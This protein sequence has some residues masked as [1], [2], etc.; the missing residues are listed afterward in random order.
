MAKAEMK[1]PEDFL[2]KISKLGSNFDSV[3]DTVLQA[4]GEVVLAKVRSNL[5][6]VVG[7][8][9]KYDSRTTGE[10]AGALGL[11][12]TKLNRDGN[13]DIKVGFA[14][15]RSDG[16]SNAKLANIIEYGKHGQPAKPFLKP[17]KTASRQE[18]IDAM[19]K[20]L[21]EEVEKLGVFY[22]IYKPSPSIAVFQW[23]RVCSPAKHRTPI[24]SSRRCRTT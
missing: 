7:R 17:A 4:G 6:S 22:P 15:P 3:A 16:G 14:E 12:P 9:T 18:C 2:L 23:K 8:G 5:S 11:S 19:T 13:H 10:L 24:W 1:M 21:D 20:A